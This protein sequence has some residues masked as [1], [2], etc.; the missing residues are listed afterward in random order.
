M[1]RPL[2]IE[3]PG[4]L[5]H[6]TARGN[7]RGPIY[8]RDADR[9]AW[10]DLLSLVCERFNFVIYAYCQMTDHY[11][12]MVETPDGN[13]SRGIRLLN[14]CYAQYIN[15]RYELVGHLFQGRYK[16]I[17]VD[18]DSYLLELSRYIVLNPVRAGVTTCAGE[19]FWSSYQATIGATMPKRWLDTASLLRHFGSTRTVAIPAYEEFVRAGVA[20]ANPLNRVSGQLLL[21]VDDFT[22]QCT[23]EIK[24]LDFSNVSRV[25]RRLFAEPIEHYA[26]SFERDEA[27]ARAYR[28]TQFTMREIGQHFGVSVTTV[29]RAVKRFIGIEF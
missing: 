16:S 27:M 4:A 29:K 11:H 25:Q 1:T 19:W 14:A 10:L 2:R 3:Y 9:Y 15:R 17:L 7:R 20:M 12:L 8:F 5:Y 24:T 28:S 23:H 18:K 13:L 26:M 21:G 22:G 6:V